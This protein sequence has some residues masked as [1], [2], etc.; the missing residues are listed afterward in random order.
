M[1]RL[2]VAEQQRV[3]VAKA[4]AIN[5]KVLIMDEP[6]STLTGKE[7]DDLFEI[8]EK[9][10]REAA[11]TTIGPRASSRVSRSIQN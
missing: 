8:I 4:L 7:I 10:S 2:T 9:P 11:R 1:S 3:E 5:A 6:T